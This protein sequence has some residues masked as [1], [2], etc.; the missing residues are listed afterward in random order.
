MAEFSLPSRAALQKHR[1][2]VLELGLEFTL[3]ATSI[4]MSKPMT[5]RIR[6]LSLLDRSTLKDLPEPV[7]ATVWAGLKDLQKEQKR[8]QEEGGDPESLLDALKSNERTLAAADPFCVAAFIEPRV[9]ATTDDL[10]GDPDAWVV[11]DLA[12]EDRLA[13]F[14]ICADAESEQ[15]KKLRVFRPRSVVDVSHH[16]VVPT[17]PAPLRTLGPEER[18]VYAD[19]VPRL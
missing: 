17:A 16:T 5:A 8:I 19:A 14:I 7:Q 6:R 11:T 9:V 10:N 3:A 4:G 2:N 15:A 18:G 13:V 12:P 1:E